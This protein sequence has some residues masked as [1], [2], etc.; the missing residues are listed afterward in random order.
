[1][2]TL[3]RQDLIDG[4]A[5]QLGC[6]SESVASLLAFTEGFRLIVGEGWRD[7]LPDALIRKAYEGAPWARDVLAASVD[8][9]VSLLAL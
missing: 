7:V 2:V 1:M 6:D 9:F 3:S 5:C 4:T 8:P